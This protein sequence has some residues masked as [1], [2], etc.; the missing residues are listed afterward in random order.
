MKLRDLGQEFV[1][2]VIEPLIQGMVRV[3][4]TP[5]GV[6]ATGLI[7]NVV[8]AAVFVYAGFVENHEASL[9]YVGWGGFLIL[10]AG[11]FDMMDG[12]LA[13]VG[14]MSSTYGALFDSVLDRYSELVTLVG[15]SFYF[16]LRGYMVSA[17]LAAVALVGSMMVSYVRARA[18]GLGIECKVGTMQRPERVIL[19][20][21]GAMLVGIFHYFAGNA[22][23]DV[24][25]LP[26]AAF[27]PLYLLVWPL[28]AVAVFA[29][30]TATSRMR[31]CKKEL[32]KPT[33]SNKLK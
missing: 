16:V 4:I 26:V 28:T 12:R 30:V 20:G 8:A 19:V 17:I 29:N 27:E 18:E 7:L 3:G 31:H 22:V 6:T 25:W 33:N 2:K 10:F 9:A 1:Y 13:R 11:L 24:D 5:N 21:A 15:I 23:V 14:G 32:E